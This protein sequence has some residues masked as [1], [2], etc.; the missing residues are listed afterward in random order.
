MLGILSP[1]SALAQSSTG[2]SL[3]ILSSGSRELVLQLNIAEIQVETI[4]QGSQ[5]Y[6]RLLIPNM[7]QKNVPGAPQIPTR[8]TMV[9]IGTPENVSAEL[10][11]A[12]IE[13]L[14]G[15]QLLPA[16]TLEVEGD[17][18]ADPEQAR[19]KETYVPDPAIYTTNAFF[20]AD[21][22]EIGETGYI[23]DQAVAQI[24][25][26]PVQ[27][28]PVTGE[29]RLYRRL[30]VRVSWPASNLTLTGD[31]SN[32]LAS[33]AYEK[34]LKRTLLNYDLLDRPGL[35]E[36]APPY[37]PNS[38]GA[39][40]TTPRLKIKVTKDAVY[41]LTPADL[42]QAGF[43]LAGVDS[44]TIKI[45][46]HGSQIPIYLFDSN[47]N[48]LFDGNDYLLFYGTAITDVYTTAN[49]YWLEA[50]G[51]FGTRMS[52]KIGSGT[53]TPTSFPA[54]LHTQEDTYYWS[55]KGSG[56]L[57]EDHWF[58]GDRITAPN[59]QSYIIT[60]NNIASSN[61]TLRVR[62][63]GRTSG[64][65]RTEVYLNGSLV[66][67][68]SWSGQ[69][70]KDQSVN[71]A[72][73]QNGNNTVTIKPT[74]AGEQ[75]HVNWIEIDYSDTYVAESNNLFFRAPS[76][77]SYQFNVSNF[78]SND[79]KIFDITDRNNVAII[80]NT[81][82]APVGSTFSVTF[83]DTASTSTRYLATAYYQL[84]SSLKMDQA[85][86]WK[87]VNNRADYVIITHD[88]FSGAASNLAAHRRNSGLEVVIVKIEDIYDEFNYG[89]FNPK[90]IQD[91]LKR[92]LS[93]NKVP[94]YVLLIGG[95]TYDY[96]D[97]L[98]FSR[99]NYVPTQ[100]IEL[101]SEDPSQDITI[102]DNWFVL[103][104]GT[105]VLPD[106]YIGRLAAQSSSEANAMVNKI[107]SYDQN[108]PTS[109][110]NQAALLVADYDPTNLSNSITYE[111]TSDSLANRLPNGYTA[112]KVYQRQIPEPKA[113][114]IDDLNNTGSIL[115]NYA[116]HGSVNG[117]TSA[118]LTTSDIQAL[119]N[120]R[121]PVV[122]VA[123]CLNGYFVDRLTSIAEEFQRRPS[124][125]AIAVWAPS[126][127]GYPTDHRVMVEQFYDSIFQYDY[128][129]LG[130]IT[131]AAKFE[132]YN[133]NNALDML[134]ETYVFFGDPAQ[135]LG[136][137]QKSPA[138]GKVEV[139]LPLVI[140]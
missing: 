129:E 11:D 5:T 123:N 13:I 30:T 118:I 101:G 26:Y 87:N 138:P 91:F 125:G 22:V 98:G 90:A 73:L 66:S 71:V 16:P 9:G 107:I 68:Q 61:A 130:V 31:N 75:I 65:H 137:P 133:L 49:V 122:T 33:P 70:I 52:T 53:L 6:Q 51:S 25:F 45:I 44:R 21:L 3:H 23:R 40:D 136:V 17:I 135:I 114:I 134:V 8:G 120:N 62:L 57:A 27:Y 81:A 84:P 83:R 69:I 55:G 32:S 119:T 110:W 20:P 140:K 43:E 102:S 77:G 82:I 99:K 74:V 126:S 124:A 2:S 89:I 56:G 85:S 76:A 95:A 139:F 106:M 128:Y 92:S 41:R 18:L 35:V 7:V 96:R 63:K 24:Q 132:A 116:G 64:S 39:A 105:D 72:N 28:N 60:V 12:D 48:N 14:S 131:T 78:S 4:E 50:G 19:L 109:A 100:V 111:L 112:K 86:D 1:E 42:T 104:S 79:I 121:W 38:I 88:D 93:W 67:N 108:P 54:T 80:N 113:A 94:T 103:V 15:Y 115:V 46:N 36:V 47:S 10:L 37:V 97:L 117:W 127:I 29:V 59:S 58:W 34:L